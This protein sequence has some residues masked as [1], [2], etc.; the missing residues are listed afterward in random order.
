MKYYVILKEVEREDGADLVV[1]VVGVYTSRE[2]AEKVLD[3]A[4][5]EFAEE[6]NSF[7]TVERDS[8]GISAFNMGFYGSEHIFISIQEVNNDYLPNQPRE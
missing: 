2:T 3:M 7:N 5:K 6:L 4:S 8:T 1:D